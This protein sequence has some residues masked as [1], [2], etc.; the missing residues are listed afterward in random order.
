MRTAKL[1]DPKRRWKDIW[2]WITENQ[3]EGVHRNELVQ[4]M[5]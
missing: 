1:E 3:C 5:V 4:D 2:K